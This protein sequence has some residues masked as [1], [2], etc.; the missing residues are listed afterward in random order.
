MSNSTLDTLPAPLAHGEDTTDRTNNLIWRAF[1]AEESDEATELIEKIPKI[2]QAKQLK[3]YDDILEK[4]D[5]SLSPE[6]TDELKELIRDDAYDFVALRLP[7]DVVRNIGIPLPESVEDSDT[8]P[9]DTTDILV[10]AQIWE[11]LDR[12]PVLAKS[13]HYL[14]G[15]K[16]ED[17]NTARDAQDYEKAFHASLQND[18]SLA[19]NL[20]V[21]N[22]ETENASEAAKEKLREKTA[23]QEV[24]AKAAENTRKREE[25]VQQLSAKVLD[26]TRAFEPLSDRDDVV[27]DRGLG[28]RHGNRV[29]DFFTKKRHTDR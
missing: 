19:L 1:N 7:S 24:L 14:I 13:I 29:A 2:D 8:M 18:R 15:E 27:L 25:R 6:A 3:A 26:D 12:D 22:D 9:I 20:R 16:L 4:F 23:N 10:V 5:S 21:I 11:T 17:E 28:R